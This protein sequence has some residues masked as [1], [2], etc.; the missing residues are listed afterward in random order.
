MNWSFLCE[1]FIHIQNPANS[2]KFDFSYQI[3]DSPKIPIFTSRVSG[4]GNIIG[5][6]SKLKVSMVKV[7]GQGHRSHDQGHC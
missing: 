3:S 5:P 7:I 2:D 6:V 4:R 1:L